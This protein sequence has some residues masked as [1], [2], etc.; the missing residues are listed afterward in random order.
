MVQTPFN[1][2]GSKFKLLPQILPLFDYNKP[3]FIDLFCGGGS[4]Y[5]N[6]LDKYNQIYVNDII[7]PLIDI[8]KGILNSDDII[9][10]TIELCPVKGDKEGFLKLRESYNN[11]KTAAKL[12]TL[13]L[14]STNN[15]I[16]FN[17]K[18][19]YN[20]TY[21]NRTWNSST[22]KKV[23]EFKTHIRKYKEKITYSQFSFSEIDLDY[24]DFMVYIDPPYSNTE[25]GYNAF[26]NKKED[27]KKLYHYIK[28][29]DAIGG[30]FMVSGIRT[31]A[32]ENA[33]LLELLIRDNYNVTNIES[34]YNKVSKKGDK[35][36]EE[37]VIKNF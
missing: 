12:W 3:N 14:C 29:I 13:M 25:A 31:H 17:K 35:S 33:M 21:G 26:W 11:D 7:G 30:S 6:V 18:F 1:Y 20:Q 27:D 2:T 34:N 36:T 37:I 19:N 10:D 15:M 16:R 9:F 24:S 4:V 8:H 22:T 23:E 32:G 28:Q 5:T